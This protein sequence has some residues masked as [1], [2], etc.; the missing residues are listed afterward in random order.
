[1]SLPA[2]KYAAW[3]WGIACIVA[4]F[5]AT[6]RFSSDMGLYPHTLPKWLFVINIADVLVI[7]LPYWFLPGRFRS[8]A[9]VPLWCMGLLYI[10]DSTY[11]RFSDEC[12]P[13]SSLMQ[14][15]NIDAPLAA[16]AVSLL[17]LSDCMYFLPAAVT[18]VLWCVRP[19]RHTVEAAAPFAWRTR[20]IIAVA[21]L[22]I[23]GRAQVVHSRNYERS[24]RWFNGREMTLRESTCERLVDRQPEYKCQHK[25]SLQQSGV[26]V[27]I[28]TEIHDLLTRTHSLHL[29]HDEREAIDHYIRRESRA[30]EPHGK[31]LVMIVVESLNASAV[32]Q[33]TT[34]VLDS[35]IHAPGSISCLKVRPQVQQ[36][37]SSDGQ[38]MYNTGLLPMRGEVA[39]QRHIENNRIPTMARLLAPAV[40]TAALFADNGRTWRKLDV[41][42]HYGYDSVLTSTDV[43]NAGFPYDSLG[44]DK[45]T[46][47]YAATLCATLHEPYFLQL[48]TI[49]T[50]YP[51]T[52]RP[53]DTDGVADVDE[54]YRKCVSYFDSALGE[55]IESL[56]RSG[57]LDHTILVVVSDHHINFDSGLNPEQPIVFIAANC[58]FTELEDREIRQ[59]DI[60]P[61]LLDLMGVKSEWRGVG[62]SMLGPHSGQ[63]DSRQW[64]VSDSIL[65]S[66][67]FRR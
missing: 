47:R 53:A 1:M 2:K 15:P 4:L 39:V 66:V 38:L 36:G 64:T 65:R 62:H 45:A 35:L 25:A 7:M 29:T 51:F 40:Y 49:S 37:I 27:Y 61:T 63:S 8:L 19:L 23:A 11:F 58:G 18:S 20:L 44:A 22:L 33:S 41:Y 42:K 52:E 9:L 54:R 24:F 55:F 16:S 3:L 21:T 17:R 48:L 28:I 60:F 31:N 13:L 57:T 43:K 26:V 56:R 30:V 59:V 12:L 32:S 10:V 67:Y 34:P 46:F 50:H 5:I 14:L 6:D